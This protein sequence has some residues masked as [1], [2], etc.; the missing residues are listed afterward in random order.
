MAKSTFPMKAGSGLLTKVVCALIAI[1]ALVMVIKH[2][3]N[4]ASFVTGAFH[5]A[6]QAVDGISTFL[7]KIAR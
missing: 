4:A 5:L 3:A 7:G 1:G 6:G 2:P